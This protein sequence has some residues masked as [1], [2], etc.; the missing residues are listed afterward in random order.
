MDRKVALIRE[1][2][3][4]LPTDRAKVETR[5]HGFA[6]LE[7]L[8]A[9]G[10]AL[11][12]GELTPSGLLHKYKLSNIPEHRMTELLHSHVA[13]ECNVCLYFDDRANGVFCFNL[14]N[15]HKQADTAVIPEME[16]AVDALR[17][18]LELHGLRPLV[19]ASGRGFHLWCRLPQPVGNDRIYALMLR[20]AAKTAAAMSARGYDYRTVKI[21]MYPDLRTRDV[22]S[23]RLF[24]SKH[25]K[26]GVFSRVLSAAGLLDEEASW[27]G[28]E[29]HL[30]A[31]AAQAGAFDAAYARLMAEF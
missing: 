4:A 24:G 2:F 8:L 20:L 29:E 1:F 23:L 28:F 18:L 30:R 5:R 19:L 14:D 25:A 6:F 12:Y 17:G 26:N 9:G 10:V 27:A 31:G 11:E 13:G 16:C 21:N 7:E 15:N 22:V 3:R